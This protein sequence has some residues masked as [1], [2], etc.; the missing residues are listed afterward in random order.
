MPGGAV[1]EEVATKASAARENTADDW[2]FPGNKGE[3]VR[4]HHHEG[5]QDREDQ[6]EEEEG[7]EVERDLRELSSANNVYSEQK[8]WSKCM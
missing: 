1:P 3:E 6:G 8:L 7:A 2:G 5:G 4:G